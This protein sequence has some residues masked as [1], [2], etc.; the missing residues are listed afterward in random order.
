MV[1]SEVEKKRWLIVARRVALAAAGLVAGLLV[2]QPREVV[3]RCV[4]AQPPSAGS[5]RAPAVGQSERLA[6]VAFR[7]SVWSW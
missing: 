1:P 2:E 6:V 7:P 5:L 4:L 3:V